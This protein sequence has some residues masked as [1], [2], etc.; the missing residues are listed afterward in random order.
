MTIEAPNEFVS[1]F[2][3]QRH[4]L[5]AR[6]ARLM[7]HDDFLE[8][9]QHARGAPEIAEL[10]S[11]S[12]EE[13][14]VVEE[15]L[16]EGQST[17]ADLRETREERVRGTR[18]LFDLAPAALLTTDAAGRIQEVNRAAAA[19]LRATQGSLEGVALD[20]FIPEREREKFRLGLSR[21]PGV[22]FVENWRLTIESVGD[23]TRAVSATV[24]VVRA[25]ERAEAVTLYWSLQ[26]IAE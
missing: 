24:H 2:S 22:D 20:R 21:V 11:T 3:R 4:E 25:N 13:L 12:I 9:V 6:V 19:M 17:I 5:I 10:L 23:G 16:R 14:R 7:S 26:P 15:E 18:R 8:R 1:A